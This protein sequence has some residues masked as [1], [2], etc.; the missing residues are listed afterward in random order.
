MPMPLTLAGAR[1]SPAAIALD[2]MAA[3]G[4]GPAQIAERQ[5]QR[6][7]AL[8]QAA[9]ATRRYRQLLSGLDTRSL[10]L[11]ALP[12]TGKQELMQQF[13]DR[14][15]DPELTLSGLQAFCADPARIDQRFLG[16][17]WV[18]ESSGST[19]QPGVFVQDETAM[20]VY[21]A[22]EGLRRHSPR[23]WARWLDPLF[24]GERIAFVSA[25]GGHFASQVSVQR[26]CELSPWLAPLRRSFSILQ[27]AAAL[28]A[29]LNDYQPSIVATYPTAAALLADQARRG[30]L[31]IRPQEVWTGGETLS[32]TLRTH[33]EQGLGCA[34]RNSYGASE[35]LP[36]AWEC[37]Q[38]SLHA[39]ADWVILEAVD[40]Q[41]RPVPAGQ[42]S[43]T[44]LLTNLANPVQPLIRFD[45]GDCISIDPLPCACGSALPVLQVQGRRDDMLSVPGRDGSPVTLLPLALSTVLE[46]G[47][48]VFDFQLRQQGP[49]A[50]CL[51]LGPGVP[52]TPELR[53]RCRQVLTDFAAAQGAADLRIATRRTDA[54]PLGASGKLKRIVAMPAAR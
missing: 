48:G 36:I 28:V 21:D 30:A 12:V 24:L 5:S 23:P 42:A 25:T 43:Q 39:N 49:L 20:A 31:R 27:P 35:F 50:W 46:D 14:V 17:Y 7:A 54:L 51:L 22:L 3:S 2:V 13:A 8:L 34:L 33:I 37:G 41:H 10:P 11:A 6:L 18:W 9:R 53:A 44:T 38:G 29:Q 4:A 26:L 32:P 52:P 1:P 40:A 19:G 16:R 15:S 45:I 47:A